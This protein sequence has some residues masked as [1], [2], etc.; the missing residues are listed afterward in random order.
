MLSRCGIVDRSRSKKKAFTRCSK[1]W[2]EE[3]G[4]KEIDS[5]LRKIKK[6]CHV[7]R[8]LAHT[9]VHICVCVLG[10]MFLHNEIIFVYWNYA[11]LVI[12]LIYS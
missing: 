2:Q 8:A 9:Q 6:Y 7:V 12:L 4:R 3:D 1:K 11:M 10:C 5:D